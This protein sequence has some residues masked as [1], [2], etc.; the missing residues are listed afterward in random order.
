MINSTSLRHQ[1]DSISIEILYPAAEALCSKIPPLT[2]SQINGLKNIGRC[3]PAVKEI[4]D[5]IN[6]QKQ[7]GESLIAEKKVTVQNYWDGIG[8]EMQSIG[9]LAKEFSEKMELGKE[10]KA[11]F[12]LALSR[13]F[14]YHLSAEQRYRLKK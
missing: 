4:T 12:E 5:Y 9:R 11:D 14:I 1:V 2:T 6:H 3:A 7:K 13:E 10:E 8:K